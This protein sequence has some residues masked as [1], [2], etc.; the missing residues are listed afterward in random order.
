[1]PA[2]ER[3]H[4]PGLDGL[5]GI[6]CLLVLIVH[7]AHSCGG[8]DSLPAYLGIVDMLGGSGVDL[9]F[10]L[11][12][13][14]I[15]G[16][17]LDAKGRPGFFSGFYARRVLRIMPLYYVALLVVFVALR[18]V[19]AN[20]DG[21]AD[22]ASDQPWF[23]LHA[24]NWCFIVNGAPRFQWLNH[25]W[26]LAIEEQF[27]L[28][29]PLV[30]WMTSRRCLAATCAVLIV[31]CPVLR[32]W[33]GAHGH[34][35]A[36]GWSTPARLDGLACGALLSIA[37]RSGAPIERVRLIAGRIA[38]IGAA[39]IA[40]ALAV[41][42]AGLGWTSAIGLIGVGLVMEAQTGSRALTLAPLRW[43]GRRSYGVY[44]Y[45]FPIMLAAEVPWAQWT[46]GA[47]PPLLNHA[48]FLVAT[49][50]A[51][52]A[53]AEVSWRGLER[54]AMSLRRYFPARGARIADP[55]PVAA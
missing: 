35:L 3:A 55:V 25:F 11:S 39:Y 52:C 42:S 54:P 31:A 37:L 29:W 15:T 27:Y 33:L 48:A 49:G 53:V 26:S 47:L 28:V 12:G 13:F 40:V 17:L 46:G 19:L 32:C 43:F 50:C 4:I 7:A 14:L 21:Y 1:M 38:A 34:D 45:H 6:A 51:A 20:A 9:F 8:M 23:W 16:I 24:A 5:R 22:L 18:P 2:P 10:V 30:V 41:G 36:A 44:V